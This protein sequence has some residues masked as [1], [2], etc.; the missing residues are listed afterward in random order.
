MRIALLTALF[1]GLAVSTLKCQQYP[2]WTGSGYTQ[3]EDHTEQ[4]LYDVNFPTAIGFLTLP[5]LC[6][7][8]KSGLPIKLGYFGNGVFIYD[9]AGYIYPVYF[10]VPEKS[11]IEEFNYGVH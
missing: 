11:Q 9:D 3:Y 8:S 5:I 10:M 7:E 4:C 1:V 2:Y 6:V